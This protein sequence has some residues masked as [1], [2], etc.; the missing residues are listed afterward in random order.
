M[1]EMFRWRNIEA[2]QPP[3]EGNYLVYT[4]DG[5]YSIKR[6]A[7][8]C[9]LKSAR[10][11]D[12]TMCYLYSAYGDEEIDGK[13]FYGFVAPGRY[14]VRCPKKEMLWMP[15]LAVPESANE[16]LEKIKKLKAQQLSI[17]EQINALRAEMK[18]GTE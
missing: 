1:D 16:N 11:H 5:K 17:Q 2:E 4:M 6:W 8:L 10:S 14:R 9:R 15:I 12:G 3:V 7:K 18:G 13:P